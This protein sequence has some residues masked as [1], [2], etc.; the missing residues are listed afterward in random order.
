MKEF[1]RKGAQEELWRK[2]WTK[3]RRIVRALKE[4][5]RIFWKNSREVFERTLEEFSDEIWRKFRG[6]TL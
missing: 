5:Q 4:L 1:E 2:F 6:I 3:L